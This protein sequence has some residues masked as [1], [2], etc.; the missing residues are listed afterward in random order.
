MLIGPRAEKLSETEVRVRREEDKRR[1]ERTRE[2]KTREEKRR[3]ERSRRG[4][5]RWIGGGR[6]GEQSGE[7]NQ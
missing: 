2:E 4:E 5:E 3:E 7:L 6:E 1:K